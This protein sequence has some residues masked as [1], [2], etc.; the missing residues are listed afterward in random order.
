MMTGW[1]L[2]A[3]AVVVSVAQIAFLG[4]VIVGRAA[5]LQN[6]QEILIKTA[7][8]DPRDLFRGD[9]VRL[10]YDI[11]NIATDVITDKGGMATTTAGPIYV[12]LL[13]Q[14][15]GF[16]TVRSASFAKP[17]TAVPADQAMIRGEVEDGWSLSP[18]TTIG[19]T[20]GI[21]RFYVPEGDGLQIE[22][23]MREHTFSILAAVD[24]NGTAQIKALMDGE[25]KLYEEPIY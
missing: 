14:P 15:D 16:W 8:V 17:E 25:K 5:I 18:G 20:Y 11:S 12:M 4:W 24:D 1:R 23:D 6:G 21:E 10:G 9:Y 19:A 2:I 7:P 3:A 13:R 22:Q